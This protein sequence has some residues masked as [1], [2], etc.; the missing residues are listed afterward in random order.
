MSIHPSPKSSPLSRG[1]FTLIEL[2]VVIGIIGILISITIPIYKVVSDGTNS[3][4]SMANLKSIGTL[5]QVYTAENNNNLPVVES[6]D[7]LD[8]TGI[9]LDIGEEELASLPSWTRDLIHLAGEADADISSRVFNCPGL[10]WKDGEDQKMKS[11]DIM[12]AYGVSEAMN[13]LD[14]STGDANFSPQKPRNVTSIENGPNTIL[15]CEMQQNSSEPFSYSQATWSEAKR[16]FSRPKASDAKI[17]DFRFKKGV[18]CLM[19]DGSA[20]NYRLKNAQ[21]EIEEPNWNGFDY[22]SIR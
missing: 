18:N 22:D 19:A 15:M 6:E 20:R 5:I 8:W 2:L 17:I 7:T 3:A 12:L 21:R 1:G 13:G 16:D 14:L 10:R 11:D 4:R 9:E